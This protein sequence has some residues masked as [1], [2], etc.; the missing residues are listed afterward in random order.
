MSYAR[1]DRLLETVA[2]RFTDINVRS[3]QAQTERRMCAL[4]A[5]KITGCSP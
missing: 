4:P 5:K 3:D 1:T 2:A